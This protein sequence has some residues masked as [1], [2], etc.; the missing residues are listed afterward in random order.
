MSTSTDHPARILIVEDD[1]A[2]ARVIQRSLTHDGYEIVASV[3]SA[4][5]ALEAVAAHQPDLT[6]MDIGIRGELDGIG[7]AL[8]MREEHGVPSV[9][10][11]GHSDGETLNR[12]VDSAPYGYVVKPFT[13]RSLHTSIQIALARRSLEVKLLESHE[14]LGNYA[15]ELEERNREL[16]A[17]AHTVAHDLQNPLALVL[18]YTDFLLSPDADVSESMQDSSL[19]AISAA[20]FTMRGIIEELMLLAAVRQEDAPH[21]PLKMHDIVSRALDQVGHLIEEASAVVHVPATWPTAI[22]YPTWIQ[23][24]W[25]NY[26]SN[27]I[28]YGGTPPVITLAS[29]V[30]SDG[31][32][33]FS[34]TDRGPG[35]PPS[36]LDRLFTPFDQLATVRAT[37]HGLGLSIVERIVHKLGGEVG[38]RSTGVPGQGAEFWFTLPAIEM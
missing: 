36:L 25:V 18:G 27:A 12:A 11:T 23:Q 1:P 32:I 38:V 17:F 37:G 3:D 7:V 19:R 26:I 16:D 5:A 34:V 10:V 14:A 21:T 33:R 28:K 8:Q 30:L 15:R 22:G 24:V 6:L 4:T 13:A 20:A 2:I 9:Y 35:I 31:Q 29:D